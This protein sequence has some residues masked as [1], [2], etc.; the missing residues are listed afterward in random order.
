[1]AVPINVRT[2]D[3]RVHSLGHTVEIMA[4]ASSI[5]DTVF[6]GTSLTGQTVVF[7]RKHILRPGRR[8]DTGPSL[9]PTGIKYQPVD[10][11][12][13][14]QRELDAILRRVAALAEKLSQ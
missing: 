14:D 4:R 2:P 8:V 11:T 7:L 1:M 9:R 3:G 6:R 10:N 13:R 5:D 12:E